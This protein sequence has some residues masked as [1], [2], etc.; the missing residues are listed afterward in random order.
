MIPLKGENIELRALEPSDL[1]FLYQ[2]ENDPE[3]WTA[4]NTITPFSKHILQKYIDNSQL[5]IYEAKQLRLMIDRRDPEGTGNQPVGTIDLFDFEAA[6]RRAGVG[7][8]IA[9]SGNR[10]QGY[11]SE[12]LSL[13]IGFAFRNLQLHQLYCNI[14]SDNAPSLAL[15]R[16]FGFLEAGLKR[17]WVRRDNRW[18]DVYMFQLINPDDR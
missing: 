4:G 18:T 6:H 17:D 7:I 13:L 9:K 5:D 16:K 2:W 1:D 8:L 3:N 14:S 12:A 15:F 10:M 11:A